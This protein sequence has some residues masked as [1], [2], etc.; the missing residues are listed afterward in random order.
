MQ[1]D[2][3]QNCRTSYLSGCMTSGL[4]QDNAD[5][6]FPHGLDQINRTTGAAIGLMTLV[7]E[8]LSG[9]GLFKIHYVVDGG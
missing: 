6:F 9:V 2:N 8:A 5:F 7:C 4:L 3:H 1:D